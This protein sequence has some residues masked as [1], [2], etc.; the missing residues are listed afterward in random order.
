MEQPRYYTHPK[1]FSWFVLTLSD[2]TEKR[3][4]AKTPKEAEAKATAKGFRIKSVQAER[5]II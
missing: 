3:T 5:K 2:G 4:V 1:E